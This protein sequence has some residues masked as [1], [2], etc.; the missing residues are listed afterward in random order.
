LSNWI[1]L[2]TNMAGTNGMLQFNDT[3]AGGYSL[4]FYRG[5]AQ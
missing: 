4:R 5:L 3:N 1:S 2:T